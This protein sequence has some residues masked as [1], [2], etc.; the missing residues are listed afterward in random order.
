MTRNGKR[1]ELICKRAVMEM[2]MYMAMWIIILVSAAFIGMTDVWTLL[3]L[4]AAWWGILGAIT[5]YKLPPKEP[6]SK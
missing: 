2:I 3:L 6:V 4:S 1:E 5:L